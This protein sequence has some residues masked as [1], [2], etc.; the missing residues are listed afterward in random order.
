METALGIPRLTSE[1]GRTTGQLRAGNLLREGSYVEAIIDTALPDRQPAPFR[2]PADA[3]PQFVAVLVP[4]TSIRLFR[5]RRR[6]ASVWAAGCP[7]CQA[8]PDIRRPEMVARDQSCNRNR[9]ISTWFLSLVQGIP[10]K[11]G[12]C[13]EHRWL[14]SRFHWALRGGRALYETAAARPSHSGMPRWAVSI[15]CSSYAIRQGAKRLPKG[16]FGDACAGQFVPNPVLP[17]SSMMLKRRASSS[18]NRR[19]DAAANESCQRTPEKGL[20]GAVSKTAE[21]GD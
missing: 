17:S 14:D 19:N 5:C 4:A 10:M 7:N 9:A 18:G 6:Y 20:V 3:V 12:N 11:S 2:H 8:Q 21:R 15:L 16:Q 13:F 1:R